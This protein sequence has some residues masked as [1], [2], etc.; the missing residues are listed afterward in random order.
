VRKIY[1]LSLLA[2]SLTGF[3]QISVAF[4]DPPFYAPVEL[5]TGIISGQ[6]LTTDNQAA[7]YVTVSLKGTN[8]ITTTDEQGFFSIRVKEG[9]YTLEVSMVGLEPQVKTIEVKKDQTTSLSITL[10]E[11][12]KKLADIIIMSRKTINEKTASI[13]KV[14]IDPM[15]LPQSIAVIGQSTIKDQQAARLSD[16][17]KNVN[18]V[19]LTTTRGNVQESFAARGY[20]FSSTN[21]FKNGFRVNSGVM[22]EVSS[23]DR[24]EVLK[25][26][27]A[28]LYGQ[29]A[30]GGV[31][32][33]VTKQPKF[34][35]GGEVA[36]RL[37]SY[38]LYKPSFDIYGPAGSSIAYRVNGTFESANSYRDYVSSKR[39]YANSSLLFKLGERTELVLEGDYLKH[40]FTPD[41]GIGS[42]DNTKI[43]NLPRS[44]FLGA[45]WSYNTTQQ[46]T[47][48]TSVKHKFNDLWSLDAAASYQLY[49]R[50][51]FSTE[52]IQAD[53]AGEWVRPLG[54]IDQ[55]ENYYAS[56]VNL[57]G[58]FK[59]KS[60]EHTLLAG[61]D[62]DRS[63]TAN[64][65]FKFPAVAGLPANSY[66]KINILDHSKY[67]QRTDMPEATKIRKR[68]A[69]T[70]RF[71]AYMQDL[72][73]L[74]DKF[75]VLAGIRWSYVE[76][77]GID[78][79]NL[80]TDAKTKG[81][82]RS[83]KA[84]SPRVG[85]VYKPASTTSI[86]ASY[87]SSFVVNTGQDIDG[88]AIIPSIV[89]QYEAGIKNDFFKGLLSVNL[90]LYRIVNNNL[91][92]TAPFLK[93]GTPNNSTSIKQLTGETTS[94]GIEIDLASQ[95][96]AGLSILAGY[97]YN[98]MRYTKTDTTVGSFKTGE[99]LVNNPAHT[100]NGS[101]FYTFYRGHLKGLKAG[102]TVVY[103]GDRFGGW[104]TDV[105]TTNPV[106][107][108]S[109]IFPVQGYTTIDVTAGYSFRKISLLAKVS[110]LANTL[111]YYV[112]E[113][114]SINPIAP[115][116][117]TATVSYKF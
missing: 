86:F 113:N 77:V 56:Q 80:L 81:A 116:Q 87:A 82:T 98:Y 112:H 29:V 12:A 74:S 97:S 40:E 35:F 42:L 107:Y 5:P 32:N 94:D 89:D 26:S 104:N 11:N 23:L 9:V 65:D 3:A 1:V 115:R 34:Q 48:T 30:P 110:N 93:D 54:K 31:V 68:E 95:P 36:M 20:S 108:R 102:V 10:A 62:A 90:T 114:Y 83:D 33:M 22:P 47:T 111:N 14:D 71:G 13:G 37:G 105:S 92:Q 21:L 57:T 55:E 39:Y 79:T 44:K 15:N 58:K 53:A 28:I 109:R 59:T 25:G 70:N 24:V 51:Y 46:T 85:L 41:F 103:L 2:L 96:V 38:D 75:N 78:S 106:K 17:I 63:F 49:K 84:F 101:A 76:T 64:Y 67:Q 18:G 6:I 69:T 4:I 27:A 43:P 100:A 91:A 99:R 7:A 45:L 72:V 117:F 50:D 73:K 88:N 66:D 60:L 16:I 19:Y 52:R 8:K 61:V